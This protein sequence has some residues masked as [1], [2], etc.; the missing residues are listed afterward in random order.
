MIY[1][2]YLNKLIEVITKGKYPGFSEFK[3][4]LANVALVSSH[5]ASL[6][7][8]YFIFKWWS[9]I[10]FAKRDYSKFKHSLI[11]ILKSINHTYY[12]KFVKVYVVK[13]GIFLIFS[14]EKG[15]PKNPRKKS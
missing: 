2:W 14:K 13:C 10:I 15:N 6:R 9:L 12:H 1:K 8:F 3:K 5:K 11:K 4:L 7:N